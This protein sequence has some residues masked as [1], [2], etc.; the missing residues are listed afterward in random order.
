MCRWIPL[1]LM[2]TLAYSQ[3]VPAICKKVAD[4]YRA[5]DGFSI[6]GDYN[7]SVRTLAGLGGSKAKL[8][9][10]GVQSA[11]KL[12]I[13]YSDG[14]LP[15]NVVSDG[16][17]TW[18]YLPNK[19]AYT[20]VE[21]VTQASSA[22]SDDFENEIQAMIAYE[23]LVPKFM[24]LDEIAKDFRLDGEQDVKTADGKVR[25]W[26]LRRTAGNETEK[27]WVDQQRFLVWRTE[28]SMQSQGN[29]RVATIALKRFDLG[30][31]DDGEFTFTPK[32]KDQLVDDLPLP[33]ASPNL[34][35]KPAFDFALK[36]VDGD[37]TR[38]SDFKGKIVVLDFWATWCPPCRHE[39]PTI[40]RLANTLKDK[41]VVFLGIN[42]E[43]ASTVK[44]F[45][46]KHEYSFT[47]LEDGKRN[48]IKAYH[49]NAI[50]N[51]YVIDR[52]GVVVKHFV[53]SREEPELM[54]AIKAA[55][56]R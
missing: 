34:V 19:K 10:E 13:E 49:A 15:E 33:N 5:L 43:G 24:H 6:E 45:N 1:F 50:P 23:N 56:L 17:V 25:C 11:R 27:E 21:A 36:N 18:T 30:K 4:R 31:P 35:G 39:L 3:D 53:G 2:A 8:R 46:K 26:V 52:N 14:F 48:V 51:V 20:K 55:G 22:E 47:T 7:F 41:D 44:G 54:A 16:T 37:E 38:L 9:I 12:H 32:A 29:S 42:D 40:N 28:A